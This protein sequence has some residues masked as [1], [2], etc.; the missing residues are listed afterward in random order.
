MLMT[1]MMGRDL[2]DDLFDSAFPHIL[3]S[4]FSAGGMMRTDI[5]EDENGFTLTVDLPGVRKENVR[6]SVKDGCLT[7]TA[8][9]DGGKEE[10]GV[11]YL[12]RERTVG[13]FSRTFYVGDTVTEEDIRAKF[14]NGVLAL[15]IPKKEALPPHDDKKY[16]DIV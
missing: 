1:G 14:E 5:T 6:A 13:N 2:F 16:I 9:L 15:F 10:D 4:G 8:V 12:R 11:K 3:P 7:V